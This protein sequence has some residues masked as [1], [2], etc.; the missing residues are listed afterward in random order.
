MPSNRC[1]RGVIVAKLTGRKNYGELV[2]VYRSILKADNNGFYLPAF[3]SLLE[4]L[5]G[6]SAGNFA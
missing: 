6:I 5:E 1:S 3:E 2:S 4:K